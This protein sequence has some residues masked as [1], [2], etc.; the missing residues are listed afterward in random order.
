MLQS[1]VKNERRTSKLIAFK[2]TYSIFFYR[3][4]IKHDNFTITSNAFC[5]RDRR[6]QY[7]PTN[8][9]G[10]IMM[11]RRPR[12]RIHCILQSKVWML[13]IMHSTIWWGRLLRDRLF[14]NSGGK[15][16]DLQRG[17]PPPPIIS[18][19]T[20]FWVRKSYS[21]N[22]INYGSLLYFILFV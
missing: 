3:V 13:P 6:V 7:Y 8:D 11:V 10:S 5:P 14:G 9:P 4:G 22:I 15:E 1:L 12:C 18:S 19:A 21:C 17:A 2:R 16:K 20:R